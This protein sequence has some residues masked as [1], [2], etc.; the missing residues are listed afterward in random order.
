MIINKKC[1]IILLIGEL[2]QVLL[3]YKISN[4]LENRILLILLINRK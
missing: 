1:T 3:N 2:V 4:L